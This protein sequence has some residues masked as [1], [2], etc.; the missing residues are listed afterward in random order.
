MRSDVIRGSEVL[1]SLA[2]RFPQLFVAPAEGAQAIH[3]LAAG[4]GVV[5][6]DASLAHFAT[7]PEDELREVET[8]AGTVEVAFLRN[9]AD[10]ETFLQIIGHKAEPVPIARTVGA[11]TYRGLADW[12]KVAAAREAYVR[13]GGDDW[14]GEFARLARE[15]GAFRAEI[16]VI[17][18]GPYSNVPAC[19]TP[20]DPDE[21][22]CI[23]REIRL[24]HECAHVVCRRTMPDNVLPVWD[25]VTADVV[26]L[27]CAIGRY[28]AAL[29]ARFL[30]VA[31]D[32]YAGGRLAE[33][34]SDEQAQRI[35]EV[36]AEV[37]AACAQIEQACGQKQASEPF[38]FLL[39]LKRAPLLAY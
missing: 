36:A 22:L 7:S 15:P 32:G 37:F 18:E 26:G 34:L 13:A 4:R 9:R 39:D 19:E 3:R 29:A 38:T 2:G 6:G 25:E 28:D 17:S 21:W 5:P 8:P 35:D 20:Y 14:P 27:L 30:G 1:A 31:P 24:H 10:F 33:Y 16:V 23:S 11:I 12:G